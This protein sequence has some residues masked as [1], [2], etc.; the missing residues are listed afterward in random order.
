MRPAHRPS[1]K[2]SFLTFIFLL[3]WTRQQLVFFWMCWISLCADLHLASTW[4]SSSYCLRISSAVR[5]V[6][7]ILGAMYVFTISSALLDN[8]NACVFIVIHSIIFVD[9]D[10]FVKADYLQRFHCLGLTFFVSPLF[11]FFTCFADQVWTQTWATFSS[12]V[13]W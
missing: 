4:T 5:D 2:F 6:V 9:F 7:M 11:P 10:G 13:W 3:F 1:L 8:T 12:S